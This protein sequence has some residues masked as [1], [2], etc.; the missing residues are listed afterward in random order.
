[1]RIPSAGH[2]YN[3][4]A[5]E[6]CLEEIKAAGVADHTWILAKPDAIARIRSVLPDAILA[7]G[8]GYTD[9]PPSPASLVTGGYRV[10]NSMYGLSN[11]RIEAYHDAGLWVNL[12]VVD[13]PWQY[14]RFWLA[15][16]DSVTTNDPQ[17]FLAL[18]HP[19]LAVPYS[20]YLP[21]WGLLGLIA[22]FVFY[23]KTRT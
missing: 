14:S 4:K 22:A 6:L 19:V 10:V 5:L 17:A 15:G 20:I 13:E 21:G 8:I 1:L 12:W 9:D 18:P 23:W 3:V 16:A 7:A 2:P 11:R